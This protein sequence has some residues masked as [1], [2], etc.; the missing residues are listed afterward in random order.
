MK[1]WIAV[2]VA[3]LVA[4]SVWVITLTTIITP[5]PPTL[6]TLDS[7]RQDQS[8]VEPSPEEEAID[9]ED[10]EPL[11]STETF[12]DDRTTS[13]ESEPITTSEVIE[14]TIPERVEREDVRNGDAIAYGEGVS[15][16]TLLLQID[17]D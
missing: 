8:L 2:I 11:D 4:I 3:A 17:E 5:E 12:E 16:D 9:E 7:S 1:K 14:E 10:P 13:Q 6:T 15:I